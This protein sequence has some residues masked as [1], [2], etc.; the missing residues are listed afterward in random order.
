MA[1][2]LVLIVLSL[3][4]LQCI[5]SPDTFLQ[6]QDQAIYSLT[7]KCMIMCLDVFPICIPALRSFLSELLEVSDFTSA[8]LP[9]F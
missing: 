7:A 5:V 4:W 6:I 1:K 2:A 3:I 8:S 9:Y